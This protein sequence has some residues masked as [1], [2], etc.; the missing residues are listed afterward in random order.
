[1]ATSRSLGTLT[2][3]LVAK[4]QGFTQGMDAAERKADRSTRNIERQMRERAKAIDKAW[5]D[6]SAAA[7]RAGAVIGAVAVLVGSKMVSAATETANLAIEYDKL[8][9]LSGTTN[10][11][12]QRMAAGAETVGI[13]AEKLA[14][15][16][17]DVQD[18]A[19]DFAQT[20]GGGMADFFEN[21]A[22]KVGVTID[23]FRKLSGPDALQLYV[24]SLEKANLS[25][26]DMIFYMEAVASDSAVLLPLLRDN[27]AEFTRLGDAADR[28]GAIM[29][30]SALDAAKAY[31]QESDALDIAMKGLRVELMEQ[32]LPNITEFNRQL[33]DPEIQQGISNTIKLI[34]GLASTVTSLASEF[35]LGM[36]HA[37]GFW[38]ALMKFGLTNPF[39]SSQD[40]LAGLNKELTAWEEKRARYEANGVAA[41]LK[42]ADEEIRGIK[43][44]IGYYEA[45][46]RS[47]VN[48]ELAPLEA[49]GR[50]GLPS[51]TSLDTPASR[52]LSP[53]VSKAK[54]TG[55]TDAQKEADKEA[56]A[57]KRYLQT[58]RE[59]ADGRKEMNALEQLAYDLQEK[60]VKLSGADQANAEKLATLAIF[61]ADG[62][63]R[64][65]Q[66]E[67]AHNDLMREGAS[68]TESLLTPT[69]KYAQQIAGLNE[70]L[71]AGSIA[72]ETYGRAVDKY[73]KELTDQ[74]TDYTKQ[75]AENMMNILGDW[76][77]NGL[78]GSFKDILASFANMLLK[79]EMQALSA[80]I[81]GSFFGGGGGGTSILGGLFGGLFGG[82][83]AHGGSVSPGTLYEVNENGPEMI[84]VGGR[85]YLMTGSQA[86]YV[87][88][89]ATAAG[90]SGAGG[91]TVNVPIAMDMGG[92]MS[93]DPS[94]LENVGA[95]LSKA[96]KPA[97][98]EEVARMMRPGG[99]LWNTRNGRG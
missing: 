99:L 6:A 63:E 31:K 11:G 37:D 61:R 89:S 54:K 88:P 38:D 40:Q 33:T 84:S 79:M 92:G 55:K 71:A 93:A 51:Y 69:E 72:P 60:R 83:R 96:V 41:G 42:V 39:K 21:I 28:A 56:E 34:G 2:I 3:D 94:T 90:G 15:I 44:R 57:A 67:Q 9:A 73:Y 46:S 70:L 32:L 19:G 53:V 82:G 35:A 80:N 75:A 52:A 77:V 65:Q 12:F 26:Q 81:M 85:D 5:D 78:D 59:L 4:I 7:G 1:M 36:A 25:Q 22:P 74:S 64:A 97:V 24:S 66:A 16:F 47:K 58:L 27:G 91:L 23:Q 17:K 29:G 62:L 30:G 95:Q 68:L 20:G 43:Q 86:G 48:A 13:S 87:T 50:Q 76:L 98:Q 18:K 8:A 49:L 10:E 45:L 14:D